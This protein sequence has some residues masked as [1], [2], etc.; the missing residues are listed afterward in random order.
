M[1]AKTEPRR[2]GLRLALAGLI[3]LMLLALGHT[4]LWRWAGAQLEAGF[5][6]WAK[7]RRAQGWEVEHGAP[8]RGGWPL[9]ATLT[10]PGLRLAGGGTYLP[11]G[12]DWLAG[13]VRLRLGL[14]H[15]QTLIVDLPDAQRLTT[16]WGDLSFAAERLEVLLTLVPGGPPRD[17][18]LVAER[19]RF[20]TPDG[21]MTLRD[22]RASIETRSTAIE[23]EPALALSLTAQE[24]ALPRPGPLGPRI[25]DLTLDLALTGP[26]P[27]GRQPRERATA[28]RDGGGTLELKTLALHWGPLAL[29]GAAT[30]ALD[31]RLQ[32]MGAG[33][34]RLA[35]AEALIDALAANGA[36]DRRAAGQLKPM[37]ALVTV[38]PA[39]GGA[40]HVE[41]PLT[42]ER[43]RLSAA[44]LPLVTFP[45]LDWPTEPVG[46]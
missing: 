27:P 31:E 40:P 34:L 4:L 8:V 26:L 12:V 1:T 37:L 39:D 22:L 29:T 7:A 21:A 20:G 30:M 28:W 19:L 36:L 16:H 5:H 15:V 13:S 11:G 44:R 24:A 23:S 14:P 3:C 41:L 33:T 42:L 10:I 38:K 18:R 6:A 32:P 25:E 9:S 17:G 43:R 45:V 2:P 35:H 46:P